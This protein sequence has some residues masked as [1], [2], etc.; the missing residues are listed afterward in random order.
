MERYLD[1][2]LIVNGSMDAFLIILTAR[3]LH[4]PLNAKRIIGG[5]L[6]GEIPVLL[7]AY[8]PT[9]L[10]FELSK[11][12]IPWFMVWLAYPYRG[13]RLYFRVLLLFW[14]LSAGLGGMVYALWGWVTF[15]GLIGES[16]RIGL[17]N[18]WV[19]L[20]VSALWWIGQKA[21]QRGLLITA[22]L[23]PSLYDLTISFGTGGPPIEVRALLDT[24]NQLR[25]PLTDVPVIL[26]EEELAATG[27]PDE[28]LPALKASWRE[29]DDPWSWLLKADPDWLRYFV[30]IPYQAVGHKSWL[31]GI[32][33][34]RIVCTSSPEPKEIKATLALV[35]QVLSSDGAYQALL[36]P[37]HVRGVGDGL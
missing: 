28:L 13:I 12:I 10:F 15:D 20:V 24:G 11:F 33:P 35:Q 36:H 37:E 14:I 5:V 4:V 8:Y 30:F 9:S 29:L 31:L 23:T 2:D 21:W 16:L 18:L 22:Q 1:L 3:L 6:A 7:S 17:K 27:I 32:R 26:V 25:D 19:L 34:Q